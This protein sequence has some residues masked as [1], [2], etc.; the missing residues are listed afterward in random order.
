MTFRTWL[1]SAVA[2]ASVL[3]ACSSS[4]SSGGISATYAAVKAHCA[5][6]NNYAE[7]DTK[8]QVYTGANGFVFDEALVE[9]C[10]ASVNAGICNSVFCDEALKE[11]GSLAVGAPCFDDAQCSS[12][13]CS[14]ADGCGV[15]QA[16]A[17]CASCAAGEVCTPDGCEA[18]ITFVDKG[19]SCGR[20]AYCNDRLS[21]VKG[22]CV[23]AP[24]VGDA[25]ATNEG[26][27]GASCEVGAYC[28]AKNTC[29]AFAKLGESCANAR[30]VNT[31]VCGEGKICKEYSNKA[32]AAACTSGDACDG[33]AGVCSKGVCVARGKSGE[34]CSFDTCA[35]GLRCNNTC[36]PAVPACK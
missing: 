33:G 8:A 27:R 23:D 9:K 24:K 20:R 35:T 6:V 25:C 36:E 12:A 30:C 22:A 32:I 16:N 18:P 14:A 15:C 5:S 34:A 3:S 7:I 17:M 29:V 4:S 28:G 11:Q 1:V 2:L 26:S 31:L 13:R 21:C 19:G 10:T